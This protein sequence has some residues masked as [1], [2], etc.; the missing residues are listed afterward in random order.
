MIQ[1]QIRRDYVAAVE[2]KLKQHPLAMFPH[3][4]D[5]MTPELFDNV[6]SVLDPDIVPLH[7]LRLQETVRRMKVKKVVQCQGRMKGKE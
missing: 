2:E 5:H 1:K 6:V 7:F 4:R 3:Y